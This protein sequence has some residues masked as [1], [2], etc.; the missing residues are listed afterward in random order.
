[1]FATFVIGLR[2]G[3]EAALIVGIVGAFLIQHDERRSIRAMWVGVGLAVAVCVALAFALDLAQQRLPLKAR[4]SMEGILT[5]AAV[6]GVTYMLIWMRRHSRHLKADLEA[7]TAEAL[8]KNSTR[9]LIG[10]AFIAVIRE[11]LETA[12][13]LFA[14]LEGSADVEIGLVGALT[15]I[16]VASVLGYGIY[17]G[18]ARINL[19]RFFRVTGVVLVLVAAGLVASSIHEFAEAGVVGWG[20]SPALDLT[21]IIVPGSIRASLTTAFLGFRPVPTYAE[22]A[23]WLLFLIPASWYVL[24]P[25]RRVSSLRRAG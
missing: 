9:T 18:G 15:G 7:K 12:I 1:M 23:G 6:G 4:E 19:S 2:E 11:G 5:L 3:L 17:K 10:L 14:L 13:F 22:L 8:N 24:R 25:Q 21:A 16:A 20:Q